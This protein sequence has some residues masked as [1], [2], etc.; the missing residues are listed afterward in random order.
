[1]GVS[2]A[3]RVQN[4]ATGRRRDVPRAERSEDQPCHAAGIVE[5]MSDDAFYSPNYRPSP[6]ARQ[7]GEPL[8]SLVKDERTWSALFAV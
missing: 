4:D 1:M 7:P 6:R 8:W 3:W 5:S 2:G